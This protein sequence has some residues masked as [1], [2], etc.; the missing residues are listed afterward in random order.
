MGALWT[1]SFDKQNQEE[2]INDTDCKVIET[3]VKHS[4]A[5]DEVVKKI[6]SKALW[7]MRNRLKDSQHYKAIGK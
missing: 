2:I 3:F 7:T 5:D 6:C 4:K 1:L